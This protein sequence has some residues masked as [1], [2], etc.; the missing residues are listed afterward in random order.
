MKNDLSKYQRNRV[1]KLDSVVQSVNI[2]R[3]HKVF[4]EVNSVNLSAF[5]RDALD[6]LIE[7]NK[8]TRKGKAKGKANE[9]ETR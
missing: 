1:D 4:L 3:R 5:V 9:D 7:A 6:S 2:E 8:S